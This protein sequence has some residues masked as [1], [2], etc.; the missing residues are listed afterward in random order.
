MIRLDP[1]EEASD[2]GEEKR[3]YYLRLMAKPGG[4]PIKTKFVTW[5]A[6]DQPT[7]S[8]PAAVSPSISTAHDDP[9][10]EVVADHLIEGFYCRCQLSQSHYEA[11]EGIKPSEGPGGDTKITKGSRSLFAG[12]SV[13]LSPPS[14]GH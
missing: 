3:F 14:D 12:A 4:K 2:M 8:S 6:D 9:V 13:I 5:S 1:S 11:R 10:L 7:S